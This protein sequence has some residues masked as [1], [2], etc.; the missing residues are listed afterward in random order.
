MTAPDFTDF[1]QQ[2]ARRWRLVTTLTVGC[3]L[4]AQGIAFV[5]PKGYT[6]SASFTPEDTKPNQLPG[7]LAGVAGQLGLLQGGGNQS[8]EFYVRLLNSRDVRERILLEPI[9]GQT[10]V[11]RYG[12][13]GRPDSLDKAN[14]KLGKDYSVSVDRTANIVR[15]DVELGS[16]SVARAVCESF[17]AEVSRFNSSLRRTLAGERRRFAERQ[18]SDA[19]VELADAENALRDFLSRNRGG[20]S[21]TLQFERARLDRRLTLAQ[22]LYLNLSH[23]VQTSRLDEVNDTPLISVVETPNLPTRKSRPN[24]ILIGIMAL[25][26]G[27]AGSIGYILFDRR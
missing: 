14:R 20:A 11:Q 25:A 10:L 8:P 2:L 1:G 13:G 18:L 16:P 21:P 7:A 17:L 24:R 4:L 3:V 27:L 19:S 15:L 5:L 9:E 22:D 23:Q 26:L 6:S 12:T